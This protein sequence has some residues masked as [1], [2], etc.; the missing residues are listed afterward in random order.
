MVAQES[1]LRVTTTANGD[2]GSLN[3]DGMV[4]V[5]PD[6]MPYQQRV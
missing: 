1:G 2:T 5:S 6:Q 3:R 4:T